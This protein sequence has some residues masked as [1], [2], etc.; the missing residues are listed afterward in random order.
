VRPYGAAADGLARV[1]QLEPEIRLGG[2]EK[3]NDPALRPLYRPR[4]SVVTEIGA[5]HLT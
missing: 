3:R 5:H 2:T 4:K 1:R